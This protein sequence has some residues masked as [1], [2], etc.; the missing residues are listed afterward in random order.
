MISRKQQDG[1]KLEQS[2][3]KEELLKV[4]HLFAEIKIIR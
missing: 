2:K 4:K 1:I 3:N